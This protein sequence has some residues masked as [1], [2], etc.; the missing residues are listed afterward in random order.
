MS[1]IIACSTGHTTNS[2]IAVIRISGKNYFDSI[3]KFF[4]INLSKLKPR[5]AYFCKI[6][7]NSEVVDEIVLTFFKGP[8][9]YNG[10]DILELSV[11]GNKLNIKRIIDLLSSNTGIRIAKPGEFSLRALNNKKLTLSEVEGLDLLLNANTIFSL[12]QGFSLLSGQLKKDFNDLY[13]IYLKHRSSVEI[14]FDFLDDLGEE[15]FQKEINNSFNG[16]KNIIFKLHSKVKN[17]REQ[18]IRPD[19]VLYGLP[20]A[21]KSTLFNYLLKD[22]RAITSNIAGTTRDFIKEDL[23]ISGNIY[24][25]IDTAGLRVSNDEIESIG[26]KKALELTKD[27]FFRIMVINPLE[28][29]NGLINQMKSNSIDLVVF[30]HNK[31]KG[32]DNSL[33]KILKRL[34]DDN[35]VGTKLNEHPSSAPIGPQ[36]TGPIEPSD[37]AP[38]GPQKTGP[39]EPS[40]SAPIGP[41]KTGPIEPAK[42]PFNRG[43]SYICC[44]LLSDDQGIDHSIF[45]LVKDKFERNL[46]FDPILI[47]R[48]CDSIKVIYNQFLEYEESFENLEDLAI[49]ASELNI[50]GDCISEL[51][52]IVSPDDVLQ[53]IFKNFCIGK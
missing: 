50:L 45:N 34:R 36:K 39:I 17:Q 26:V 32:F 14:G 24:S 35:I 42:N 46:N 9:S 4:S 28:F 37:S 8:H 1:T 25:L 21:G 49:V 18:L 29:N 30:T 15:Q 2:A 10:E 3:N 41:Q 7:E 23:Y 44:D 31:N 19:I 22:E 16:L 5:Y 38:I 51:I 43:F 13:D 11:H 12:K 48:H 53:N 47:E 40:D 6:I 20:N 27:A 33:S 52:G